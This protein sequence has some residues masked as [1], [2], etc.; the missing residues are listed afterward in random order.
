MPARK[1]LL[2]A[3]EFGP[4]FEEGRLVIVA[5]PNR[6]AAGGGPTNR[7]FARCM[8]EVF[9]GGGMR[10]RR[11]CLST[12]VF[13][14][15]LVLADGAAAQTQTTGS[16][17]GLIRDQSGAFL[18]GVEIKAE[19]PST[20]QARNTLSTETGAYTVPLLAPGRYTVSFSLAGFQTVINRNVV[21]NATEKVT[22]NVALSVAAVGTAIE[23]SSGA[24]LVQTESTTLGRVVDEKMTA[25]LPL[26][27]KNYT[28]LLAL[29]TGTS[30]SVPDTADLGRG[31]MNISANGASTSSNTFLLDGVDANN[32]HTNSARNNNVGS[33]GIPVP[34]TE[35][36]REFKV[37]AG[38]Y[39]AQ[40]GR[41]AGA[42]INVVTK[43]G[44][45]NIH[46]SIYHYFRNDV[47]NANSFFFNKTGTPRPVLRQNQFGFTVGGPLKKNKSFFFL[48]FQL[49]RQI[50]GASA[51]N[52]SASFILPNIPAVRTAQTLGQIYAGQAG[53]NGGVEIAADGSNINPVAVALL[54]VRRPDGQFYI[55]SP[56]LAGS[57]VNYSVSVPARYNEQQVT[58]SLDH[59]FTP[60]QKASVRLFGANV[61]QTVPFSETL[62]VPG[63][64][65]FQDF[66]NRNASATYTWTITPTTVNEARVGFNRPAGRSKMTNPIT[67]QQIGMLRS[68]A[69]E[70]PEI[71]QI[72]VTGQLRLGEGTNSD[73]LTI[74]NS[75]TYQDTLSLNRGSHFIRIGFEARRY[76]TNL[77]NNA[78][79]RGIMAFQ[80]FPDFLLGLPAGPTASGGNGTSF[81]NIQSTDLDAGNSQRYFRATDISGFVQDDWKFSPRVSLN[82]GLRYDFMGPQYDRWGRVG[83]FDKRYYVTPPAGGQ[84]SA[85]FVVAANT[86]FPVPGLPLVSNNLLDRT[87]K[88]NW[89]P[90]LGLVLRPFKDRP[91]V[92]RMGYGIFYDR[93]SNNLILQLLSSPP[94][95]THLSASGT[96][97]AYASFQTPFPSLPANQTYPIVPAIY[98]LPNTADRP[99]LSVTS[100][101]PDLGTPY[102][103]HY[104]VNIQHELA[105]NLLLEIGF[106]GSK[107]A[108]LRSNRNY[109][110]PLLASPENPVNGITTNTA[111]NAPQRVPFI[112]FTPTGVSYIQTGGNSIYNSVQLSVTKR[113]SN[114]LQFLSSY[115]FGKS[116]DDTGGGREERVLNRG[117]S[118]FDRP[119]RLTVSYLY[120]LPLKG[121]FLLEGWQVSGVVTAQSGTP[122]SITDSSG[123]QLYGA[124]NSRA[125]FAAGQTTETATLSGKVTDRLDRYF[126]T[127]AF[128][129][130]GLE[131]GTAGVGVLRGP[132]QSNLDFALVKTTR[133]MESR[134]VEFRT[135]VFNVTNT[136]S[137]ANPSGAITSGAFGS[138]S[139]TVNNARLIQFGLRILY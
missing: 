29:S 28:Q 119:H 115:T 60:Y 99:S 124:T 139:S 2:T 56:T 109:N 105:Q 87:P 13:L 81:S 14:L 88:N 125:N 80:S 76:Q 72:T 5:L 59:E 27:T 62:Q 129:R 84:T 66:K 92:V 10:F 85:G 102:L 46:G 114:G 23:V 40:F 100:L 6:G 20:A 15:T 25:A 9:F 86:K 120:E 78:H 132:S 7:L 41:N 43:S 135:E 52:S 45:N 57:G 38:Q 110:L 111:G 58:L 22:L 3:A 90:R 49:T 12:L 107:G 130:P 71:P 126:N 33:N 112:G 128:A 19:E 30:A 138:I 51:A 136:P 116:I 64:P 134:S 53:R 36:I 69:I 37:Q 1:C 95:K 8:S 11:F 63:F 50:N 91:T 93:I 123:A 55:P 31:S 48:G 26:P 137:F 17:G 16:I 89:A 39:D 98:G 35:V 97:I 94:F 68:N 32:I 47:L 96:S 108:K 133:F 70:F 77:F 73:Q 101:D 18:P 122:F 83:Q 104:S 61:P 131:W 121:H 24:Q 106:V 118:D 21:V 67:I 103:Q 44:T 42:N 34:S 113:L 65:L 117:L 82:L 74:P 79:F 4:D 127:A 54:N 75:F